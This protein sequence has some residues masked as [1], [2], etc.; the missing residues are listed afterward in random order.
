MKRSVAVISSTIALSVSLAAQGQGTPVP[1]VAT[2]N[3]ATAAGPAGVAARMKSLGYSGI[4]DLRR[5][6]DGQ[7]TGKATQNG[8][9]K[10]VTAAPD[11]TVIGR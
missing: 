11:G 8:I 3:Q 10:N 4:H 7:W 6:P 9:E 5:G 2:H 1:M